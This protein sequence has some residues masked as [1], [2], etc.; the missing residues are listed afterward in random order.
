[1][2]LSG[3]TGTFLIGSLISN[4]V[5][6]QGASGNNLVL[7]PDPNATSDSILSLPPTPGVAGYVLTSNGDDTSSWLAP[8]NTGGGNILSTLA[9]QSFGSNK[10]GS[11]IV[12]D[13]DTDDR[14]IRLSNSHFKEVNNGFEIA[15]LMITGNTIGHANTVSSINFQLASS[16][17]IN[18]RNNNSTTEV[19][20]INH[21]GDI[22][23]NSLKVANNSAIGSMT[24][25]MAITFNDS[26]IKLNNETCIENG[27]KLSNN[28]KATW[29][30]S[31]SIFRG[32]TNMIESDI[33]DLCINNKSS[34][35]HTIFKLG[36]TD[37]STSVQ[38]KNV[39]NDVLW[40]VTGD[41][42]ITPS[43]NTGNW[44]FSGNTAGIDNHPNL[45]ELS[46]DPSVTI[47]GNLNVTGTTTSG[48]TATIADTFFHVASNNTGNSVD[49]GWYGQYQRL[50]ESVK[51]AGI[52][53]DSS[54]GR[55][56]VFFDTPSSP[57]TT[58]D[59]TV[60]GYTTGLLEANLFSPSDSTIQ[61]TLTVGNINLSN[62]II[63]A[64]NGVNLMKFE[65]NSTV[66]EAPL[67]VK[68]GATF[69]NSS[70]LF[71][72]TS[73]LK[74]NTD[75]TLVLGTNNEFSIMHAGNN[76]SLTAESG[77][78]IVN[79]SNDNNICFKLG[80]GTSKFQIKDS[81][82]NSIW[83]I[84]NNG[85]STTPSTS[86][87]VGD[88]VF[89]GTKAGTSSTSDMINLSNDIVSTN[90]AVCANAP[91][92]IKDNLTVIDNNSD[93]AFMVNS[94][95]SNPFIATN[96]DK[97]FQ[98]YANPIVTALSGV[99]YTANQLLGGIIIRQNS[100]SAVTDTLPPASDIITALG[101]VINRG[102]LVHI[103]N[104]TMHNLSING[105]NG[106]VEFINGTTIGPSVTI[107]LLV[108]QVSIS[109]VAFHCL[110]RSGA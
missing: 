60:A 22:I 73:Q 14:N 46:S 42:V 93:T 61:G 13:G 29:G 16:A 101:N 52:F 76:T 81:L 18:V 30:G 109:T 37:T 57:S 19:V 10:N 78:F 66:I 20:S 87:S 104:E 75:N 43:S 110:H 8:S 48:T 72:N 70:V 34:N 62:D 97:F 91:V 1:M 65:Q 3:V 31:L 64:T 83:E 77:N 85:V 9:D 7:K 63:K 36:S 88:W 23:S 86:G 39:N 108:R 100:I 67:Y 90:V 35:G 5:T 54:H 45:I 82:N 103:K 99:T 32:T 11:V 105:N 21:L 96:Y 50:G 38:I 28:S 94:D 33:V 68:Q 55:F 107:C 40:Q 17:K 79:G 59:T 80:S 69:D 25:P 41:G 92:T 6:L 95:S 56:R 84:D 106:I 12:K 89:D 58:V 2:S 26:T 102:L 74:F 44:V 24:I 27:L 49:M 53:W 51:H 15:D 71:T 4:E 98:F 47:N